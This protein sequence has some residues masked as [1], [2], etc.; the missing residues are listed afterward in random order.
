MLAQLPPGAAH[1]GGGSVATAALYALLRAVTSPAG[2]SP[3]AAAPVRADLEGEDW[4]LDELLADRRFQLG[5]LLGISASSVLDLLV[6]ARQ[7]LREA[8]ALARGPLTPPGRAEQRH[9][10]LAYARW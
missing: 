7:R 2:P 10:A 1:A 4:D 5:V 6:W 3:A 9:P 8:W